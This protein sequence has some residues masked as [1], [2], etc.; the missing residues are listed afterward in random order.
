MNKKG[1]FAISIIFSF[2]IVFLLIIVMNLATYS[3]NRILLNQVKKDIKS[4]THLVL[5]GRKC[6]SKNPSDSSPQR[7]EEYN[8]HFNNSEVS[9]YI[10]EINDYTD[11]VLLNCNDDIIPVKKSYDLD[12]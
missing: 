1:F 5:P 2:F 8:C 6:K 10:I 9:C 7:D 3:Q 11:D 12:Y 4:Q